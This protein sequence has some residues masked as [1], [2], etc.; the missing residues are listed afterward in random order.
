VPSARHPG[1]V[2]R[3]LAPK[4]VGEACPEP[5]AHRDVAVLIKCGPQ[6]LLECRPEEAGY[7]VLV[8]AEI[9]VL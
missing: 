8:A 3:D 9:A 4:L 5:V 6:R 7:R 1:G 2:G